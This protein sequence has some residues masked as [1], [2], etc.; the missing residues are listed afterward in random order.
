MGVVYFRCRSLGEGDSG[1][2][3]QRARRPVA[4]RA[5]PWRLAGPTI[6]A[7][8]GRGA[9]VDL[10][11]AH[12]DLGVL[13]SGGTGTLGAGVVVVVF[14]VLLLVVIVVRLPDGL[15]GV[16]GRA[17]PLV[18]GQTVGVKGAPAVFT[19][20]EVGLGRGP[21]RLVEPLH[22]VAAACPDG[23]QLGWLDRGRAPHLPGQLLVPLVPLLHTLRLVDG[24][25]LTAVLPTTDVAYYRHWALTHSARLD[26]TS[27]D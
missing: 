19:R 1:R 18:D 24:D 21:R 14:T 20:D 8:E 12:Q 9:D 27:L 7:G 17:A 4:R 16:V 15:H 3:L 22:V 6:G 11:L 25:G 5:R 26:L 23:R 10:G 2:S 13:D